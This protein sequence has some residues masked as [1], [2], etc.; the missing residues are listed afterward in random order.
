MATYKTN[1]GNILQ[2]GAQINRLSSFN[3]EAVFGWPGFAAYELIAYVPI[4]NASG[5]AAS[6]KSLDLIIPSPDRRTD[7][8]VRDN[9]T[10]LVIPGS[11]AAPS[12][13]EAVDNDEDD[14]LAVFTSL[15][16]FGGAMLV[17]RVSRLSGKSLPSTSRYFDSASLKDFRILTLFGSSRRASLKSLAALR[18]LPLL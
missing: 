18:Y 15:R 11:S 7:D 9:I 12:F 14:L 8:R 6:F 17:A 1:A 2:P 13:T 3:S 5:S 16:A 10:T 4:S